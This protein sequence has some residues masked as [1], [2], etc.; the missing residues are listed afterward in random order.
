M[1]KTFIFIVFFIMLF[2][3]LKTCY[4][5]SFFS[6]M[7]V[8]ITGKPTAS[9]SDQI[10]KLYHYILLKYSFP[11]KSLIKP[12]E[13]AFA[14]NPGSRGLFGT[15][16]QKLIIY[17]VISNEEQ[18]RIIGLVKEYKKKQIILPVKLEFYKKQNRKLKYFPDGTIRGSIKLK[19]ELLRSETVK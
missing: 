3:N 12:K 16:P 1:K 7:I 2:T 18:D 19:E 9:D 15:T 13:P 8:Y 5:D 6:T 17:G 10:N 4:G 14:G 11:E